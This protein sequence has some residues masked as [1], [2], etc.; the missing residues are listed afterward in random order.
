M[1]YLPLQWHFW[2]LRSAVQKQPEFHIDNVFEYLQKKNNNLCKNGSWQ[3]PN[4]ENKPKLS[5]W[6]PVISQASVQIS[7]ILKF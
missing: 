5:L 3:P 1:N 6:H 2:Q 7:N 4:F